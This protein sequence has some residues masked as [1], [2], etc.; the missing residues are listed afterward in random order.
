VERIAVIA[1]QLERS[2]D[3]AITDD[4]PS[5]ALGREVAIEQ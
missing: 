2:R 5:D 1:E 4:L 3:R